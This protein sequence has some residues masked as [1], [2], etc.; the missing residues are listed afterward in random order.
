MTLNV[1]LY[2][3]ELDDDIFEISQNSKKFIS[4]IRNLRETSKLSDITIFYDSQNFQRFVSKIEQ[5]D[6]VYL[7]NFLNQLRIILGKKAL[8]IH[9]NISKQNDCVYIIWNLDNFPTVRYAPDVLIEITEKSIKYPQEK[10]I[11]LN[12]KNNLEND[13]KTIIVFKDAKHIQY[14]PEKF[15]HIPFITDFDEFETWLATYHIVNFS[16]FDK[17]KFKKTK[18]IQQGKAVFQELATGRFWYLDNLHKN[19]YE[20]FN[21]QKKHIGTANLEGKLDESKAVNGR[22]F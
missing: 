13:R 18:Q 15:I 12:I 7:N 3:P 14:L 21:Q 2:L 16:L 6:E 19:E 22:I 8:D 20:V 5:L 17:Q 10:F 1:F 9:Q 4:D 11:L